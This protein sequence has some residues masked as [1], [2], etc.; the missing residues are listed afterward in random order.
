MSWAAENADPEKLNPRW[1]NRLGPPTL[2]V[3]SLADGHL[4][5]P[6]LG[7]RWS[8]RSSDH[9]EGAGMADT[10]NIERLS[11]SFRDAANESKFVTTQNNGK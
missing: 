4:A 1:S 2:R 6:P 9:A 5:E 3:R 11:T 8:I 7:H 10:T